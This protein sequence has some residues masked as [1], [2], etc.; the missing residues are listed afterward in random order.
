[1]KVSW[2]YP[3]N[4]RCG[5]AVYSDAYITELTKTIDIAAY[6]VHSC[7]SQDTLKPLRESDIVH[8]QYETSFF[9]KRPG[10]LASLSRS[11]NKPLV[12]TV[13]EI[14]DKF[15]GIFPREYIAGLKILLPFKRLRYDLRHPY[16]TMYSRHAKAGFYATRI[17]IHHEYQRAIL[18]NQGSPSASIRRMPYPLKP[19]ASSTLPYA[20]RPVSLVNLGFV[21]PNY[22][23]RLLFHALERLTFDWQFTWIGGVR[24]SADSKLRASLDMEIAKRG[25]RH[26]FTITDWVSEQTKNELL[27]G[28]HV[29]LALFHAKSAS[30][31]LAAALA[32]RIPIVATDLPLYRELAADG[33]GVITCGSDP[34]AVSKAIQ[35]VLEN[36]PYRTKIIARTCS[37]IQRYSL[38]AISRQLLTLYRE[39][40]HQ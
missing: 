9:L 25:W 8:L 14:H 11:I 12:V 17:L 22:N 23:Y 19:C 10:A 37:Y 26:K 40:L 20:S 38:S 4:R 18:E 32:C 5:I 28:A 3:T 2:L 27:A 29:F 1:M 39:T 35:R 36:K 16:Q 24:R 7:H 13:H 30:E 6:D 15:P 21:T 33:A 34:H 31:S